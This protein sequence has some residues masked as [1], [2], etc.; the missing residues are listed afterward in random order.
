MPRKDSDS[1]PRKRGKDK[2]KD[3][4]NKFGKYNSRSLRCHEEQKSNIVHKNDDPI[5]NKES[6]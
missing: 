4:Y 3:R 6:K 2:M 1:A 5:Q